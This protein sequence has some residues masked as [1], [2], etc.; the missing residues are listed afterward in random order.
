MALP[1]HDHPRPPAHPQPQDPPPRRV[2]PFV[3]VCSRRPSA[4]PR[5]PPNPRP[6]RADVKCENIFLT[7]GGLAKLGD[8]GVA[9]L[10]SSHSNFAQTLVGT[11]F[12]LSPELCENRPYNERS[13]VWALG[14]VLY[15]MLTLRHPFDA[16]SQAA[17][18]VKIVR[19][20][21][22]LC[23]LRPSLSF[24]LS[25]MSPPHHRPRRPLAA[26]RNALSLHPP[27]PGFT[28]RVPPLPDSPT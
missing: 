12:Y 23:C 9:K 17:L 13:D 4:N 28:R 15:E 14:C 6:R 5:R 7:D 1:H 20:N 21:C 25:H 3:G 10:L 26:C 16:T 27:V 18:F 22:A 11:P 8:L 24:L 2:G 19:G